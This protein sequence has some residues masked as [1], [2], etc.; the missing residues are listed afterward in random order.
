M[1]KPWTLTTKKVGT[2]AYFCP[3]HAGMYGKVIV[4]KAG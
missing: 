3:F 4:R 1:G 2:L